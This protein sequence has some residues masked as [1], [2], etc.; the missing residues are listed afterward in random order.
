[1]GRG[2]ILLLLCAGALLV[3][4]L[5]V[6][7]H[8]GEIIDARFGPPVTLD[9]ELFESEWADDDDVRQI[10]LAPTKIA[11]V[12]THFFPADVYI[13]F[14]IPEQYTG[15]NDVRVLADLGHSGSMRPDPDDREFD[16]NPANP[17]RDVWIERHGNGLTWVDAPVDG[18]DAAA[19]IKEPDRWSAEMRI[20][21]AAL[22]IVEGQESTI[23]WAYFIYGQ[24]QG[25]TSMWPQG[26]SRTFPRSWADHQSSQAWMRP[27]A[28]PTA[29]ASADPT[30]GGVPLEVTFSGAASDSDGKVVLA[31]WSFGDGQGAD[32]VS[33]VHTYTSAGTFTAS[34]TVTDDQG[35]TASDSVPIEVAAAPNTPPTIDVAADHTSGSKPLTVHFSADARD[36]DGT[37]ASVRWGF[38]DASADS[39]ASGTKVTHTFVTAGSF[40]V[41]AQALDDRGESSTD[42]IVITVTRPPNTPPTVH[43]L[44]SATSGSA[45]LQVN[46]TADATDP[47]GGIAAYAWDFGDGGTASVVAPSH[48]F[49]AGS[50]EVRVR[51]TDDQ[52]GV[53]TDS[54]RIVVSAAP[55]PRPP[56]KE[57]PT[58]QPQPGPLPAPTPGPG[59]VEVLAVLSCAALLRSTWSA[60]RNGQARP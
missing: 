55:A 22:G 49:A 24:N 33:V 11:Y 18:W 6:S 42:Q 31:R 32:G 41:T 43:L 40:T 20:S 53:A 14:D 38:N 45:P 58:L 4:P 9:G 5:P 60:R 17:A 8:S 37:I 46:F 12:R 26:A 3:P 36:S 57:P 10:I 29:S 28:S 34:F 35:A 1:M 23:G 56:V 54:V 21:Y 47:D 48:T 52:G 44:P 25:D 51:V 59:V 15:L 2:V 39:T 7:A 27:N 13:A 19:N 16:F 30:S 50:Y